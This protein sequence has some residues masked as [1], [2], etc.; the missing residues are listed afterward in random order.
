MHSDFITRP[1]KQPSS[2]GLS[3]QI[4]T[5]VLLSIPTSASLLSISCSHRASLPVSRSPPSPDSSKLNPYYL[6]PRASEIHG[7][8]CYFQKVPSDPIITELIILVP[9]PLFSLTF[10]IKI[11]QLAC[12]SSTSSNSPRPGLCLLFSDVDLSPR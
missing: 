7:A 8:F 5:A 11:K 12:T 4:V 2:P 3:Q 6:L 9:Y 1:C 10:P